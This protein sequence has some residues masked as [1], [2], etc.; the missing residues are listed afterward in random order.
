M[1]GLELTL[2]LREK[3]V[4]VEVVEVVEVEDDSWQVSVSTCR[5]GP[6]PECT[7]CCLEYLPCQQLPAPWL[8]SAG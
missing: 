2:V 7:E 1:L 4:M 3:V 8:A 6:G 5:L